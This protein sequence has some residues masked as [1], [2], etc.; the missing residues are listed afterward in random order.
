MNFL[1]RIIEINDVDSAIAEMRAIGVHDAGLQIMSAKAVFRA[2]KIK[3]VSVTAANI[4]KQDMLSR[5]GEAATSHGT[6]NHSDD[7]TDVL[8]LG[9]LSQYKEVL[10]RLKAQ[11]FKLPEIS[12][13]IERTLGLSGSFPEPIAGLE[14]GKKSHIMGVLNVTPDS[15]SDGGDFNSIES[16]IKHVNEMI[17]DG[18]AIIDVGGESTRPGSK[19][20]PV[21]EEIIRIVPV[22]E[23]IH[24]NALISIDTRKSAVAEAAIK[25]GAG[26]IND[27]SGLRFDKNMAAVAAKHK[28]PVVIMHS[29][30]D[31]ENMQKAPKYED[32]I[33]EILQFFDESMQYAIKEGVKEQNIILDPGIGFG[34]TV[35]HNIEILKKLSEF[36]SFGRPLC[37]GTSRKSFIGKILGEDDPKKRVEGTL[38]TIVLAISK[39]VDIIRIHDTKNLNKI[40][41]VADAITRR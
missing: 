22:I 40:V 19:E 20:V 41:C 6:I 8:L 39:K 33:S 16:A 15:F 13:Q 2:V 32:L 37:I 18:A 29:Q 11:Q 17:I 10:D 5:G 30:G 1:P 34:K 21:E 7:K 25:A 28:V 27:V 23:K 26:I 31:P 38:A 9:T 36:R 12:R 4:L 14:F 24:A 35:E 3:N